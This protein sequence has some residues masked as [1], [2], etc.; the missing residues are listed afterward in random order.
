MYF[1]LLFLLITS[2]LIGMDISQP[3]SITITVNRGS[4]E[5]DEI[6][7]QIAEALQ[8]SLQHYKEQAVDAQL[9]LDLKDKDLK[10]ERLKLYAACAGMAGVVVTSIA[11]IL[12]VVLSMDCNT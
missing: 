5:S 7:N 6:T 11:T 12:A 4:G 3:D 9:Q 2:S 8:Q 10:E 1:F